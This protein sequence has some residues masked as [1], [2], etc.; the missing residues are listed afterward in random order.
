MEGSTQ[1][2][3]PAYTVRIDFRVGS[4]GTLG[5]HD[6]ASLQSLDS[7]VLDQIANRVAARLKSDAAL[8]SD[9]G[10]R[11]SPG[12]PRAL[13]ILSDDEILALGIIVASHLPLPL[14]LYKRLFT[15]LD[16]TRQVRS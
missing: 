16:W 9:R 8:K 3:Y 1:F 7:K 4:T 6:N 13:A 12:R 5:P 15:E 11:Q 10:T 2:V 14:E